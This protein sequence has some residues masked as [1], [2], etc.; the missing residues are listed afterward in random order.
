MNE[1]SQKYYPT[2]LQAIHLV[3]LY[4]FIQTIVDFPLAVL[5]YYNG[6][7]YLYH[8]VKK[9]TLGVGSVLFILVYGFKKSKAPLS[10][11]FPL[12][13][14]NPLVLI[15]IITFFW[16]MHNLLEIVSIWMDKVIPPPD[17]FWELF[18]KIFDSDYGWWGAFFKVA[19]LA[20]V[21]EELIF[22]GLI[23]QGFRRNYNGFFAVFI[24]ALLFALFHLNPWQFPATFILGL[25]LGWI[26][27]RTNS[28]LLVI[29]GHSINNALVLLS[30][31]YWEPIRS[32]PIYLM[33]KKDLYFVS[34]LVVLCSIV[35]IYLLSINWWKK[36]NG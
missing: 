29:L 4:I 22:R 2:V 5:D 7:D 32:H 13:F 25:L 11:V 8:P 21:I 12:K 30:I 17:W 14:F 28:I 34:T 6:T 9:I 10:K 24:S 16:G 1:V 27:L 26:M 23:L 20:P 33:E 15:P 18:S 3:I 35:V 31:T 19:V 36:S